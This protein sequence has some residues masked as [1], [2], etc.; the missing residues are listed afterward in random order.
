MGL[1]GKRQKID[2]GLEQAVLSQFE[3]NRHADA[4]APCRLLGDQRT[5]L[6]RGSKSE[7]AG[8][9]TTKRKNGKPQIASH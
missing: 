1:K 4:V 2:H 6:G 9:P 7:N 3:R 8:A 5:R